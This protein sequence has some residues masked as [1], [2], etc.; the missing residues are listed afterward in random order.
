LPPPPS[1]A[2]DPASPRRKSSKPLPAMFSMPVSVC[3]R[4]D[5]SLGTV[6]VQKTS[7]V[8][9]ARSSALA[10]YAAAKQLEAEANP[11]KWPIRL[12]PFLQRG[13]Q[14]ALL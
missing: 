14:F 8:L 1:S 10:H 4:A 9:E 2:F 7:P 5:L 6:E 3:A 13:P 11:Q 12:H